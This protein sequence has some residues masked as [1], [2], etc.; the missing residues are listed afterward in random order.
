MYLRREQFR[1]DVTLV[2]ENYYLSR[3]GTKHLLK[4]T[5]SPELQEIPLILL[6]GETSTSQ[7]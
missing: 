1:I 7:R 6:E 4:L 3:V 2:E 5:N